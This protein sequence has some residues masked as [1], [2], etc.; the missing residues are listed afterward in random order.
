MITHGHVHVN[1]AHRTP[2]FWLLWAVLCLNVS[3]GIGVIGMASPMLQEVFGGRLIGLAG[4]L[5]DLSTADKLRVASIGAGFAGLLSLFN[6]AGRIFWASLSDYIGRK[7]T[8]AIFFGLGLALYA[9]VPFAGRISSPALFVALFC[10]ILTMYGGGFAT[11]PAYLADLFGTQFVGAIH[12]RLLTA[13]STAG[14]LGPVLVNYIREF[15]IA[16]G[17]P[18]EA[19]YNKTMLILAGLLAL[20]FLANM[21]VRPVAARRFMSD[22]ELAKERKLGHEKASVPASEPESVP[23]SRASWAAVAAA[24]TAIGIPLAWGIWKTVEKALALFR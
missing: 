15:Q 19:S 5:A 11:I 12:G 17:V 9:V 22:E 24:W 7:R 2:Q 21:L 4:P 8:Y 3:A 14:V 20:G 23:S 1:S 16:R 13:W 18:P 10:L 6:I